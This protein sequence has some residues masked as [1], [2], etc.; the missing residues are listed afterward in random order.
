MVS[1]AVPQGSVNGNFVRFVDTN[2]AISGIQPPESNGFT[3]VSFQIQTNGGSLLRP[4]NFTAIM[5]SSVANTLSSTN[6]LCAAI[7][8]NHTNSWILMDNYCSSSRF[9]STTTYTN[10]GMVS[11]ATCSIGHIAIFT[12]CPLRGCDNI[13]QQ[14]NQTSCACE[15][16]ISPS[17]CPSN[18]IFNGVKCSCDCFGSCPADHVP[19]P[20]SCQCIPRSQCPLQELATQCNRHGQFPNFTACACQCRPC[21]NGFSY[22]NPNTCSCNCSGIYGGAS[23]DH[24]LA[25]LNG[26]DG[27]DGANGTHG[28]HQFDLGVNP[29][30]VGGVT[31]P[32]QGRVT[33][34]SVSLNTAALV[35]WNNGNPQAVASV[36]MFPIN[37]DSLMN[38]SSNPIPGSVLLGFE[39]DISVDNGLTITNLSGQLNGTAYLS[40]QLTNFNTSGQA[41]EC[42][43]FDLPSATWI[44]TAQQCQAAGFQNSQYLWDPSTATLQCPV[45]HLSSFAVFA[46]Q[47]TTPTNTSAAPHLMIT[48]LSFFFIVI[49]LFLLLLLLWSSFSHLHLP[50][51]SPICI[52][53]VC[54]CVCVILQQLLNPIQSNPIPIQSNQNYYHPITIII[55]P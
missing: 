44:S 21:F 1:F 18:T 8:D 3:G 27:T 11:F 30:S 51:V 12:C 17:S 2:G 4:L 39:M 19:E 46:T 20:G 54:V 14:I 52:V 15:C 7:F 48:L 9:R 36:S 25:P 10:A 32:Q 16:P 47:T 42:R 23:C 49:N 31:A 34:T 53:C 40:F 13:Y 28:T 45:C 37:G 6:G 43:Y 22:S 29:I 41:F 24:I 33:T 35:V 38:L 5:P 50:F 55:N 26:T